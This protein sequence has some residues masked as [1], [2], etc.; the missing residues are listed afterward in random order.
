[1]AASAGATRQGSTPRHGAGI[2][3]RK[4]IGDLAGAVGARPDGNDHLEFARVF[5]VEYPADGGLKMAFLVE[6]RH[7]Y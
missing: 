6:Y 4:R 5:L 7:H 3:R 1:M 2:S